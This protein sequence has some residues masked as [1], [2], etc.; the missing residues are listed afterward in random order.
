MDEIGKFVN[1]LPPNVKAGI[2]YMENGQAQFVAPLTS[3]H[4]AILKES[5][6]SPGQRWYQRE[7]LFLPVRSGEALA[8]SGRGGAAG[9]GDGDRRRG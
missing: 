2:A 3:D 4:A 9:S 8:G 6:S 7:S 5:P 1:S